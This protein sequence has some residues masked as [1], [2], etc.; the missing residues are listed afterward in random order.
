VS[1]TE[2]D[3]RTVVAV[4]ADDRGWMICGSVDGVAVDTPKSLSAAAAAN[5]LRLLLPDPVPGRA[6]A[7]HGRGEIAALDR[8]ADERLGPEVGRRAADL[9]AE[10]ER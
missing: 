10:D 5:Y 6:A 7:P 8:L 1:G 3:R 4:V 2:R 9:D